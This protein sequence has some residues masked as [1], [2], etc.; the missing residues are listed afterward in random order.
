[1]LAYFMGMGGL[2]IGFVIGKVYSDYK[3]KKKSN[4]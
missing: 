4:N 1:M 2:A 3:H